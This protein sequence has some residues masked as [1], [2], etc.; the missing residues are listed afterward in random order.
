[1]E[2]LT[3]EQMKNISLGIAAEMTAKDRA[4]RLGDNGKTGDQLVIVWRVRGVRV[5]STNGDPVWE[6][7]DLAE[8]AE[9]LESEGIT[10]ETRGRKPVEPGI[11]RPLVS[12][13]LRPDTLAAIDA[14]R[15]VNESRGQVIDRWAMDRREP[16]L[17]DK[18]TA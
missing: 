6:E 1:M 10:L 15:Q 11:K 16:S 17:A 5:A 13:S 12:V 18:I 4:E 8:F 3:K 9:L 2:K 14:D 7:S